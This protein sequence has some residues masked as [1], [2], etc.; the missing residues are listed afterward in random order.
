MDNYMIMI[1]KFFEIAYNK[2]I[3]QRDELKAKNDESRL[4]KN[5][6]PGSLQR[7]KRILEL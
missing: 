5:D 4:D 6:I 2:F 1:Q 3:Q 7:L